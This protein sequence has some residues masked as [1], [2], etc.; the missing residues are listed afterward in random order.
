MAT[1]LP[2]AGTSES[3]L[4]RDV[5]AGTYAIESADEVPARVSVTLDRDF[6]PE[7]SWTIDATGHRW[8]RE[9][10]LSVNTRTMG[11]SVDEL[12]AAAGEGGFVLRPVSLDG[13]GQPTRASALQIARCGSAIV[14]LVDGRGYMESGGLWI[15][16]GS[17]AEFV[18]EPDE[19]VEIRL[20]IRNTPKP[21]LVTLEGQGWREYVSLRPSEERLVELPAEFGSRTVSVRV[22]SANGARPID[23]EPGSMDTRTLGVWI[24]PR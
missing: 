17:S 9:I 24:E 5:P 22:S 20:F 21:N 19:R 7:W 16:G 8:R 13:S 10:H 23:F 6:P 15:A 2:H 1:L 18:L 14:Y 3:A 12:A 11:V 4:L